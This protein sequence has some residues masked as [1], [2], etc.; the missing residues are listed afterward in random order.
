MVWLTL[1]AWL[2]A[3][4]KFD[5]LKAWLTVPA[6]P[7][8]DSWSEVR[9][10]FVA[11][12][13]EAIGILISIQYAVYIASLGNYAIT[14]GGTNKIARR[15]L[16]VAWFIFSAFIVYFGICIF[17]TLSQYAFDPKHSARFG[18]A[19]LAVLTG[20]G[21]GTLTA[22]FVWRLFGPNFRI[23][24]AIIGAGVFV[25]LSLAYSLPVYHQQLVQLL[26]GFGIASLKTPVGELTFVEQ[27]RPRATFGVGPNAGQ[28]YSP[29]AVP[30]SSDPT[31]G[32]KF[33][34]QD[35]S[36]KPWEDP[37]D[38]G[39]LA[40]D[41]DYIAF[42]NPDAKDDAKNH[43]KDNADKIIENMTPLLKPLHRLS[44][45]LL[46]YVDVV[47]DSELL[48]VDVK[49]VLELLFRLQTSITPTH[50]ERSPTNN[51][52]REQFW[53]QWVGLYDA[54]NNVMKVIQENFK[55]VPNVSSE[56]E[57]SL[58]LTNHVIPVGEYAKSMEYVT[59]LQ[60]YIAIALSS[61]LMAVGSTDEGVDVLAK[62]LDEW[63]CARGEMVDDSCAER[64]FHFVEASQ[65]L[66]EWLRYRAEFQMN[67][68]L[69]QLIGV[70]NII[71][72]DFIRKHSEG[73]KGFRR[74][75]IGRGVSLESSVKHCDDKAK[76]SGMLESKDLGMLRSKEPG[77][78][79]SKDPETLKQ[80]R[81][82][83][84]QILLDDENSYLLAER[85]FLFQDELE[86]SKLENLYRRGQL[87]ARFTPECIEPREKAFRLTET[88]WKPVAAG[89]KVTAGLLGVAIADRMGRIADSAYDQRRAE[90]ILKESATFLR[91]GRNVLMESRDQYQKDHANDLLSD[92]VFT[93]FPQ[94]DVYALASQAIER[95]NAAEH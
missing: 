36:D 93:T 77:M 44:H 69:T 28:N 39:F 91:D 94:D 18:D 32:L 51:G 14:Y 4:A 3:A 73:D 63:A 83:V 9:I 76:D 67:V 57:P 26:H 55:N 17:V 56:C 13:L 34:R 7:A 2:T 54:T 53:E 50:E 21:F 35:T 42:F 10:F 90:E 23:T 29:N 33:L 37:L 75:A 74:L 82:N 45:C 70:N 81:I 19:F 49:P 41:K 47:R 6:L 43:A 61:L 40:K 5:L 86:S 85:N 68:L 12:S 89:Y 60:P 52:M 22:R 95:L 88:T 66:P 65:L 38:P 24:E 80:I 62:W 20:V 84:L 59:P 30:R 58:E 87:L 27:Q 46:A 78:L 72:R 8:A 16:W 79:E 1:K 25:L 11:A 15:T 31:P 71:Y 64:G 92:R 48:A